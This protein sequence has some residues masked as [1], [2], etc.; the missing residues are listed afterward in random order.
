MLKQFLAI[1]LLVFASLFVNAQC[2]V[3]FEDNGTIGSTSLTP[4]YIGC[5][6][7]NYTL[8]VRSPDALGPYTIV[9]GDGSANTTGA[10]L[11]AF[12]TV[13]HTYTYPPSDTFNIS[14]TA[15][16]C[17]ANGFVVVEQPVNASIQIPVGGITQTCAPAILS[18]VN[19]STNVSITTEFTWD[20]GDGTPIQVFDY[21]NAGDTVSHQYNVG[22]VNCN[23]VVT[24]TA[25]NFCSYGTPTQAVFDPILVW[26]ID[27]AAIGASDVVLC[28][29]DTTFTFN[30]ASNFNCTGPGEGNTVPRWEFWNLGNYWT[31][32]D[33]TIGWQPVPSPPITVGFPGIGSYTITMLDSNQCGID[34]ATI[35]VDVVAPPTITMTSSDDTICEGEP[36]TFTEVVGAGGNVI[37]WD[38][39][40]GNVDA[41]A[42]PKTHIYTAS[43]T[44]EVKVYVGI[45]GAAGCI[46]SASVMV[47][48]LPSPTA[49]IN[50]N[51][52]QGCDSLDVLFADGSAGAIAW[53]WDFGNGDTSILQNP[54][55]VSYDSVANYTVSL[56]VE[57]IFGCQDT[58]TEVINVFQTP[59][60]LFSPSS[61]CTN[62][63]SQFTDSSTSAVGDPV[64]AW[65]WDFG[66][67]LPNSTLQ[68][69]T[70]TYTASGNYNLF[71]RVSTA[72]CS[73]SDTVVVTVEPLPAADFTRNDTAGCSPLSVDFTNAS[74]ANAVSYF[75]DFGDGDTSTAQN[76][77]HVFTNNFGIDTTYYVQLVAYTAFGCTDTITYP[78]DVFPNPTAAFIHDA[79]LDCAPLIVNYTNTSVGGAVS[80]LWTFD[81]GDTTSVVSPTDTLEN[82][83]L[84][85]DFQQVELVAFSNNGCTDTNTQTITVY[86][87]PQFDFSTNPDSG[88]S[89]LE[90]NF[91][92]VLGAVVYSWDFGDGNFAT[93]A[94]PTH[95][96]VNN[97][98][99]DVTYTATLIATS[100]FGC[101]DTNSNDVLV[102]PNPFANFAV[103]SNLGCQPLSIDFTNLSTGGVNF[104]WI[105]DDGDTLDTT[106]VNVSHTYTNTTT[107]NLVRNA[108]LIARTNRGCADTANSQITIFPFVS[109]VISGDTAGCSPYT[110]N[111]TNLSVNGSTY[112][113]DFGDGS[114]NST[115]TNV[116]H[117][118]INAG[119]TDTTYNVR[120]VTQS[121]D[122]CFDTAFHAVRVFPK[123]FAQFNVNAVE[124]CSPLVVEFQNLSQPGL[125]YRWDFADGDTLD[126]TLVNVSHTYVNLTD[127]SVVYDASLIVE[128]T[129]GCRDTA[130]QALTAHAVVTAAFD[131]DSIGCSPFGA[132]FTNLSSS[133][134][135][136]FAWDFGDGGTS[137]DENPI[138]PYI[139]NDP[140]ED[141]SIVQL[142]AISP[143]GCSDTAYGRVI[144]FPAPQAIFNLDF[145]TRT[146]PD[147]VFTVNNSTT[148]PGIWNYF[149]DFGDGDTSNLAFPGQKAYTGWGTYLITLVAYN[150]YCADTAIDSAIILPP[151]PVADFIPDTA[152]CWPLT[153]T[154]TNLSQYAQSYF[155]RFQH[156]TSLNENIHVV[157]NPTVTF[158]ETGT[159]HV[160]LTVT[161]EGGTVEEIKTN[162][163]EVYEVPVA[164]FT[165]EPQTVFVPNEAIVCFNRTSFEN[166]QPNYTW[167]FGD[168][169]GSNDENPRH[170][171]EDTGSYVI[172]LI[173]D[174][175][176]C[177][178]TLVSNTEIK[179][180]SG[181]SIRVPTAFTPNPNGPSNGGIYDPDDTNNDIFYPVVEN[182]KKYELNIF[183]KWGELIFV[184]NETRIGWDGYYR[185]R[186]CQQDVYVW[187]VKATLND[188]SE[189]IEVGDVTLLR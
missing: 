133:A 160:S 94:S 43:G 107:S 34:P 42:G 95:T 49:N 139:N 123:P 115:D 188:D 11:P 182:A 82:Q 87:Q 170:F 17:T 164:S 142:V 62:V 97:T 117:T 74:S 13:S 150:D 121:S 38:Y 103:S 177:A 77:T 131:Y 105:F 132:T 99:N 39:G 171:Y 51:N 93:G 120:L 65:L 173:A 23:T 118:F 147:T 181:G 80:Y 119:T 9:W 114:A 143:F 136:S 7:G 110:V 98:T 91:P 64:V 129:F 16:G 137:T 2:P 48:V 58:D 70:H 165:V 35:T 88:C 161:G 178:D 153:V 6:G 28:Y 53:N 176:F 144:V 183:N 21:T 166:T 75:W 109:A 101:T 10:S 57:N 128:N 127:S 31:G 157:E 3:F 140:V 73:D 122:N 111:F 134:A 116:T 55:Q 60:P 163:I 112:L 90:V 72:T 187:K 169:S 69:P 84:F 41:G 159:Y 79:I 86:P 174:N 71:L 100:S 184:S 19:S 145:K 1:C 24:L 61:V 154:F 186:L 135:N 141:T 66:D 26:D 172:T 124:G 52:Q 149:W 63:L 76:P 148:N 33:S 152:G 151:L 126:T 67:G 92:S 50:L 20:F 179:A 45:A 102:H 36:V 59:V 185:G 108:Q 54:P 156:S 158:F 18:F 138:H 180:I 78:V 81:N 25:E 113:W 5:S 68:N 14:I 85:I 189:V 104:E 89:P 167:D 168:G 40:D 15:N 44:Y 47:E 22:T 30:N 29:P 12:S 130:T 162:Y 37:T 32:S 96:Y 83:T 4:L 155:W 8:N 56:T 146:Y 106:F 46:D 175:G 125:D 27:D